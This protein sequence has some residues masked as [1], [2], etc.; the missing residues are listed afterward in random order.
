MFEQQAEKHPGLLLVE[1]LKDMQRF[2]LGRQGA[3]REAADSTQ[4]VAV[5]YLTSVL[6]PSHT[7][8]GLRN[9]RELRTLAEA[10]DSIV[11]DE[12]LGVGDLLA[13]RF[14]AVEMASTENSWHLARHLELIPESGV[15]VTSVQARAEA[16]RL[17]RL[18]VRLRR[19]SSQ[20]GAQPRGGRHQG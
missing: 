16:S 6:Q 8:I 1:L 4:P 18:G 20:P 7:Q 15:S 5:A 9:G 13:Q 17:E 12:V 3:P 10:I 2:L 19:G 11:R 14:R